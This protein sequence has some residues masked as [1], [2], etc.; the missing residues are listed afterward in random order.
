MASFSAL[1]SDFL[2]PV[3]SMDK[4][5]TQDTPS[6][7]DDMT[8]HGQ[9]GGVST[10]HLYIKGCKAYITYRNHT[11]IRQF[12]TGIPQ[13]GVLSPTLFNIYTADLPSP[14]S[15]VQV[16]VYADDITI[17]YTHTSMHTAKKDIQPYPHKVFAW[18]NITI[19]H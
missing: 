19:A 5:D 1:G 10:D 8:A 15:P 11:S 2:S 13:G 9:C 18:T 14:R 4:E 6:N 3:S 16:M 7:L 17:T 12:K